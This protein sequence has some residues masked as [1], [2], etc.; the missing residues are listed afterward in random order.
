[1]CAKAEV[2]VLRLS[3]DV[4][5][6]GVAVMLRTDL[7]RQWSCRAVPRAQLQ[8]QGLPGS[9]RLQPGERGWDGQH[10]SRDVEWLTKGVAR[11]T[12][13]KHP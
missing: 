3:V 11:G 6:A 13:R 1:M 9:C 7:G 2:S 5:V 10:R 12:Q 4:D 8:L